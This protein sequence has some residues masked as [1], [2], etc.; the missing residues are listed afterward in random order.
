[1]STTDQQQDETAEQDRSWL[2]TDVDGRPVRFWIGVGLVIAAVT[3]GVGAGWVWG[4]DRGMPMADGTDAGMDAPMDESMD[5]MATTDARLPPV[6]GLYDGEQVFFVHPEASDPDVADV[7]T[8]MMG[9]SPVLVV[10]EL[11]EV[12]TS[13]R[14]EVYVFTNGIQGMGPFGFQPDVF[15]SAPGDDAYRPL[16][17][18]V[19][20][21]WVD[22]GRAQLLGS[23][24]QV[25]AAADAG[26]V[27]LDPTD[28]VVNMP[29]LT[30]PGGQ[31]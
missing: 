15:P 26:D 20:V 11:A 7:L 17:T 14:D 25:A 18:I 28:V 24:D 16:R 8:R 22:D 12:P 10:P 3:L 13:A 31:R 2:D 21:T 5:D 1:M 30:W 27:V 9:G 19:L 23:A 6:A 29:L 4:L